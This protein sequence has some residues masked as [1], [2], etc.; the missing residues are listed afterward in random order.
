MEHFLTTFYFDLLRTEKAKGLFKNRVVFIFCYQVSMCI[1]LEIFTIRYYKL[2]PMHSRRPSVGVAVFV[3][4]KW[5]GVYINAK[6]LV[7]FSGGK[8]H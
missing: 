5:N 3:R 8:E 4:F 7:L 6:H 2:G 1:H